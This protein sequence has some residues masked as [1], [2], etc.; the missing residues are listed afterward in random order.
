MYLSVPPIPSL[1]IAKSNEEFSETTEEEHVSSV[2]TSSTDCDNLTQ[3]TTQNT[4]NQTSNSTT[5][6]YK[7]TQFNTVD[8]SDSVNNSS[9]LL[10]TDSESRTTN[11]STYTSNNEHPTTNNSNPVHDN[12][13]DNK[14]QDK[15]SNLMHNDE[16]I[17][18]IQQTQ[19]FYNT[20]PSDPPN[21]TY[22]VTETSLRQF[23]AFCGPWKRKGSYP[24]HSSQSG[25]TMSITKFVH[26]QDST[27][28]KSVY[29]LPSG[30][31]MYM[32]NGLC[33][34]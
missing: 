3:N 25:I 22:F 30:W 34:A 4:T 16:I 14:K 10:S 19:N 1:L 11:S 32:Y 29:R 26:A 33:P 24:Y 18:T 7:Q 8:P 28:T 13:P 31:A 2:Q 20:V 21:N 27:Y 23:S 12:E 9:G 6:T 15:P 5:T 17:L